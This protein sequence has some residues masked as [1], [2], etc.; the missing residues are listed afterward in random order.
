MLQLFITHTY[1]LKESRIARQFSNIKSR[2]D[3]PRDGMVI[4]N[5]LSQI[6]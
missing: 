6:D 3:R 4:D 2:S 1:E 5:G